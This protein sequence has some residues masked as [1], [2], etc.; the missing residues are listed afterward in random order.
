MGFRFGRSAWLDAGLSVCD[1]EVDMTKQPEELKMIEW[2]E[3][4][5]AGVGYTD[6]EVSA[7]LRRLHEVK[8]DLLKT[9]GNIVDAN[10]LA[11][12]APYNTA[13]SFHDW[14]RSRSQSAIDKATGET[15]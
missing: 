7:A 1:R 10:Y 8:E 5:D 15:E 2:L 14:V 4:E 13:E 9:L 6:K 12:D 3:D 11:W